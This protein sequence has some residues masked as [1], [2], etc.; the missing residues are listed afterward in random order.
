MGKIWYGWIMNLGWAIVYVGFSYLL[1]GYGAVGVA[2][3]LAIAYFFHTVWVTVWVRK[4]IS[5]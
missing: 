4:K 5:E 1:L 2:G 3:A